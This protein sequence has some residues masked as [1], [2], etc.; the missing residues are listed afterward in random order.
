MKSAS[1]DW[2]S[3]REVLVEAEDL[4]AVAAHGGED[5]GGVEEAGV[6]EGDGGGVFVDEVAVEPGGGHSGDDRRSPGSDRQTRGG[7]SRR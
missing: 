6:A 4:P 2:R 1:Q 5:A 3:R 7:Q